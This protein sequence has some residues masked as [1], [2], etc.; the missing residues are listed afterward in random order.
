MVHF[1]QI[2]V[3]YI[4]VDNS[5]NYGQLGLFKLTIRKTRRKDVNKLISRPLLLFDSQMVC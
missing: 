5:H 2:E 4:E 3:E 1:L